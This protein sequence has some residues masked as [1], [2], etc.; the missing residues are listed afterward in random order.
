MSHF[1]IS[2]AALVF[3]FILGCTS[4]NEENP[5]PPPPKTVF[6]P[7]QQPLER[8]RDVQQTIDQGAQRERAAI[9]GASRA[10]D[11]P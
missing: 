7:L 4:R 3:S 8:A 5:P 1:K 11:T 10:D 6:D 2:T 9:D